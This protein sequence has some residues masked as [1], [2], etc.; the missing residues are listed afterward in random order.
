MED[1]EVGGGEM[2]CGG[3]ADPAR[4]IYRKIR[5]GIIRCGGHVAQNSSSVGNRQLVSR[6]RVYPSIIIN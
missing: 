5:Q 6:M 2:A 1:V 4:L 3:E